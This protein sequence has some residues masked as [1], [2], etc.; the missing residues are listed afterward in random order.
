MQSI[1]L[2]V[3]LIEIF[4]IFSADPPVH[5]KYTWGKPR[6]F[7]SWER[8]HRA[9]REGVAL[10]DMSFMAKFLVQGRDAGA[11]INRC[12]DIILSSVC[13]VEYSIPRDYGAFRIYCL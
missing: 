13:A 2:C 11:A 3:V 1:K 4:L 6:F 5:P 7:A 9:C 10:I 8:E 12:V